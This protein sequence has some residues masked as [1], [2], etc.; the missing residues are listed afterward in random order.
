MCEKHFIENVSR[1]NQGRIIVRLPI[2]ENK[3]RT[4]GESHGIA[5][6]R[7][8][9]LKRRL[10][11]DSALRCQYSEFMREYL[12]LGHMKL[13][14]I[15]DQAGGD[16]IAYYL[17]HHSVLKPSS[18][19]TKL[20]VVFDGSCKGTTGV[21]LNDVLMIGPTVQ[22]DI[23]S[24]ILRFRFFKFAFTADI[25]KMY[26][27][28]LID[29]A[30]TCLQRILW[31]DN[32]N[33]EIQ[34]YELAT[35]T[36]GT[37]AASYLATRSLKYLAELY[38]EQFPAGA[39]RI[40]R[41]FYVDDILTGADTVEAAVEA[42]DQI[43]KILNRGS[44]QLNKWSS[45]NADILN[46]V[47]GVNVAKINVNKESVSRVLGI[48]W[49]SSSDT[50]RFLIEPQS[51]PVRQIT[52]R[53]ILSEIA[54]LFDPIGFLGPAIVIPKLLMQ[55][56]WQLGIHWDESV[57]LS[58]Y[59]KW[60]VF[61][62]QFV[63]LNNL[64][65]PRCVG[66]LDDGAVQL[67]GFC[68]ASQRAYGA[69]I[70][71]RSRDSQSGFSVNLLCSRT[72]VAPLK[73]VSLP[74]L[75]LCAALLLSQL[76]NKVRASVDLQ[77][78]EIFLWSDS[79]VTL[80][81]ISSISR[82]W[83]VFVANRIGE[84]QG[85][86]QRS[87]WRHVPSSANPADLLSRGVQPRDLLNSSLWWRGPEFLMLDS[88]SWPSCDLSIEECDVPKLKR[89]E[90]QK[91]ISAPVVIDG[92]LLNLID[93][94]SNLNKICRIV[95]YCLRCF[96]SRSRVCAGAGL[97][98]SHHETSAAL[99]ALCRIVQG[100]VF[101]NEITLL[102][103][104]AP[105][106][107]SPLVSLSPFLDDQGLLRVGGRLKNSQLTYDACHQILLPKNHRLTQLIIQQEHVRGL[108]AGLQ[109]TIAA[110]RRR[111]WPLSVRSITRKIIR[112][113]ITC[114][115]CKP[116]VS[117]AKMGV[118]PPPRVTP[119]RTFSNSGVDYAGPFIIREGKRRNARNSKAYACLFVCLAT[120][121]IHIE[122]VSDLTS[123]S[124]LAS[125]KRFISRRGA[126][127]SIYSDNGTTFVGAARQLSEL[128]KFLNLAD[129]Q[130]RVIKHCND[131]GI[132]WHFIPPNAPHF[133]GLWESAVK[134]T[135]HHLRRI[136]GEAH[137]T[138]EELQTVLCE[139]EAILNSRPLIA[140]SSDPN[141]LSY[142]TPGHFLVGGVLGGFPCRDLR[143]VNENRLVRWQRVEQLRQH[144]WSRWSLEYL[145]QLQQRNKWPANKG[146]QLKTGQLVLI[147]Q[148]GTTPLSWVRGRVR[149]VHPGPDG[150]ARSATIT[151]TNGSLTRPLTRISILQIDM[152]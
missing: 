25:T 86:T 95:A 57:P 152:N 17:P 109:G 35:I 45:N 69:C 34:T 19:T 6:R 31:R 51:S 18:E 12:S 127:N 150:V 110:V 39:Q 133:G 46:N 66:S 30:Q 123:D 141:D 44:L 41:D 43:I 60:S 144:F 137:L 58:I 61:R 83:G 4:L 145:N 52:K 75:E 10:S 94:F 142:L 81:W 120:K 132:T 121:A 89:S 9:S 1:N 68:D 114:F 23:M 47:P 42:R 40:I 65:I 20:R 32:E 108:H 37:S 63:E 11:R 27:Q 117:E 97:V 38:H 84:I 53:S 101:C 134:S 136:V 33:S 72:R 100:C 59:S 70:Y 24:I 140:L 85:L 112:N 55:E 67:H 49:N 148:P 73:A 8:H 103:K 76:L 104:G 22:Q 88:D 129:T 80:H 146:E 151:T 90:L 56:M 126:P 5:L 122:L 113:C 91:L 7:F 149:E 87:N 77:S 124:F 79:M 118:L 135:K 74:R 130:E 21:S 78:V 147:K 105:L 48:N 50:F 16:S 92:T 116:V 131:L 64:S 107:S 138:F 143:D 62:S 3:L 26:R 106:G 111:F 54:Q 139:I 36:Y 71:I 102:I 115:K 119:S 93:R 2:K 15:G 125:L 98:V 29:P 99:N 13:V 14:N 28:I 96:K 82:K 128:H